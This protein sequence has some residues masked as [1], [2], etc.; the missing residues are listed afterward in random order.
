MVG[1]LLIVGAV[2]VVG[3]AVWKKDV[4][5]PLLIRAKN[6]VVSKVSKPKQ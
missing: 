2:V 6:W 1:T 3:L 4:S 5:L